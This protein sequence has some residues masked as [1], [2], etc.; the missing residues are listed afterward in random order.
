[1]SNVAITGEYFIG[2]IAGIAGEL[3]TNAMIT[4]CYN[5]G[6]ITSTGKTVADG[7]LTSN[8]ALTGGIAGNNYGIIAKCVN[9]GTITANYQVNG[10][11]AGRNLR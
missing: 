4:D 1:M 9:Q 7:A 10:G 2:G 8:A 3:N 6:D 11:I 5:E